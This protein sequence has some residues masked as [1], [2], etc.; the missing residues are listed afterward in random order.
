MCH[1]LLE[2][3]TASRDGPSKDVKLSTEDLHRFL[4]LLTCEVRGYRATQG[5]EQTLQKR[6]KADVPAKFGKVHPSVPLK[7]ARIFHY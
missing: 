1:Q 2:I 3:S 7:L 5:R 6:K 4:M